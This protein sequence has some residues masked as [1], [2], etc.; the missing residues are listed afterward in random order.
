M[1]D[2]QPLL[3]AVLFII[4]LNIALINYDSYYAVCG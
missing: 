1:A 4:V 2:L 3:V